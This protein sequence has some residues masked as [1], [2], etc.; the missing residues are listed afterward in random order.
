MEENAEKTTPLKN[1]ILSIYFLIG[2][3]EGGIATFFLIQQ[4]SELEQSFFL[5]LS[6]QRLF[7]AFGNLALAFFFLFVAIYLSNHPSLEKQ[8]KSRLKEPKTTVF[9]FSVSTLLVIFAFLIPDYRFA[10]Y[11]GYIERLRPTIIWFALIAIQTLFL[12]F[13]DRIKEPRGAKEHGWGL[14]TFLFLFI[15]LWGFIAWSGLGINPDDRYWNETGVPLLNEQILFAII[16]SFL[17]AFLLKKRGIPKKDA[18]IFLALWGLAA[19]LWI[20][21]PLP[22]NFFAPGPYPPNFELAP[23]ADPATFDLGGQFAIIGQGLFNGDFYA[24]SLLSGFLAFLH[25]LV[26]QNYST[27]VALQTAI[28]ASLVPILYLIGKSLHSRLAGIL[29][30]FLVIFKGINAIASSTWILSAHPK[31]MLTEWATAIMLALFTL[32]FIR[33]QKKGMQK[34][35]LLIL[36]G[37]ALGLGIMLRTN[38]LFSSPCALVHLLKISMGLAKGSKRNPRFLP[39]FFLH[40]LPVDVAKSES[41][42]STFLFLGYYRR[43]H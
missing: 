35:T 15:L 23:Y 37:G 6:R 5:G 42:K 12:L 24:R 3:I 28:F 2:A 10:N 40:H 20:K 16:L 41:G 32:W 19:F 11:L 8:L 13:V 33:W 34:E 29:I 21:E 18:L 39:R 36:S 22:H 4:P 43:G 31:Y 1:R 7:L 30:A 17:F 9:L 26:G 27:V 38:I 25:L 14:W